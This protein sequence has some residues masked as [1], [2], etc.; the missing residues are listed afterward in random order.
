MHENPKNSFN[1]LSI[2]NLHVFYLVVIFEFAVSIKMYH[3]KCKTCFF[4]L[5]KYFITT[6]S[7]K[8]I[9]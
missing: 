3:I 9:L 8:I 2:E 6:I 4:F 1:D 5:Q 7:I